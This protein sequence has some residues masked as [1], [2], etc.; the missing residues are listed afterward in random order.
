[1]E[2]AQRTYGLTV[3]SYPHNCGYWLGLN[4]EF[5][6]FMLYFVASNLKLLRR[7]AIDCAQM[8]GLS[9]ISVEFFQRLNTQLCSLRSIPAAIF[10]RSIF[11]IFNLKDRPFMVSAPQRCLKLLRIRT[12]CII[13]LQHSVQSQ[14]KRSSSQLSKNWCKNKIITH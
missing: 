4:L 2:K 14:Q 11:V 8:L 3:S 1:M 12:R 7:I 10:W 6:F 5:L 13:I 9:A